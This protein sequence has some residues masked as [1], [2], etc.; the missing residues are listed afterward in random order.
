MS[1]WFVKFHAGCFA[2]DD[3]PQLGGPVEVDGDQIETLIESNQHYTT[4]EIADILRIST[5][6]KLLVK[7]KNVSFI[8]CKKL[9]GLFGHPVPGYSLSLSLKPRV[10]QTRHLLL[11]EFN[12][13]SLVYV[14]DRHCCVLFYHVLLIFDFIFPFVLDVHAICPW[15]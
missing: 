6:I 1:K 5:S 15:V 7:M 8:F 13:L 3:V 12:K 9:N 2:L 4:W 10:R 14:K 11:A